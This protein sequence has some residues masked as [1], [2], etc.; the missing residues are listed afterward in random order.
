M[1]VWR[2]QDNFQALC[3]LLPCVLQANWTENIQAILLS[4]HTYC[5]KGMLGLQGHTTKSSF[6]RFNVF[7]FYVDLC[8]APP[9]GLWATRVQCPWR[10]EEGTR[11]SGT[12]VR[13]VV[14]HPV[15]HWN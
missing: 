15:G 1:Q 7:L 4:P 14:N 3:L 8:F 9:V 12:R 13:D 6:V 2:S 5:L 11:A 10:A